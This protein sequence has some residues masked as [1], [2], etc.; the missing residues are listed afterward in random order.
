VQAHE[1]LRLRD[2]VVRQCRLQRFD[3]RRR[4][5]ALGLDLSRS[6]PSGLAID[7]GASAEVSAEASDATVNSGLVM[8]FAP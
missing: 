3:V 8:G 2:A 5:G 1:V 4:R 7:S 6:K